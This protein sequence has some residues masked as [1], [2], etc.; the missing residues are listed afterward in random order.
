MNTESQSHGANEAGLHFGPI[1]RLPVILQQEAAE[2]GLACLAMVS[3]Y[4]RHAVDLPTLRHRFSLTPQG[5]TLSQLM[6]CAEQM[7]LMG[8]PVRLDLDELHDLQVPAILHWGLNH[9]VVLRKVGR[10]HIVIHDPAVGT[11]RISWKDAD[12][13]FTGVALELSP[14]TA[15]RRKSAPPPVAIRQL[16]GQIVGLKRSLV[17][18]FGFA[19]ALEACAL[20][21][22]L[23]TQ[24]VLDNVL[25]AGDLS[26]LN[27]LAISFTVLLLLQVAIGLARS[28]VLIWI[29]NQFTYGWTANVYRHL[30]R[31]PLNYFLARHLG[32][33]ASRFSAISAIQQTLT[34]QLVEAIVDGLMAAITLVMLLVYSP[35]L[36][37]IVVSGVA[38]Y[39]LSRI[40]FYSVFREANL[41]VLSVH[42]Q[43]QTRFLESVRGVQAIRLNNL[44]AIQS[45]R[46]MNAVA[47]SMNTDI[48]V[49][50]LSLGF[51]AFN[52]IATGLPR[53]LVLWA[54]AILALDG[55]LSAGMLLAF[56]AYADQFAQRGSALVDHVIQLRLL[57][58]QGERLAD[59]VLTPPE[60]NADGTYVGPTPRATLTLT[61]VGFRYGDAS[62]WVLRDCSLEVEEGE[63]VAIIGPSGCGKSTLLRLLS[64]LLEPQTG[65]VSMG[66]IPIG[67][68]GKR[69]FRE[70]ISC[71][72]QDD[73]LIA[74]TLADN[75]SLFDP[76]ASQEDIERA[77][78]LA[79]LHDDICDMPMGYSTLVGDMGSTLSGGQRQRVWLARAI[80]RNPRILILDEATSHLDLITEQAITAA[81]KERPITRIVVA[82]RPE[83]ISRAD[84]VLALMDG[85]LVEFGRGG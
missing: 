31:L 16:A 27:L 43:E 69:R 24:L 45:S 13:S 28:W 48:G 80:Y 34:A 19:L 62:P 51:G 29:G 9:F 71:V 76:K 77:A 70:S 10:R 66:D 59:I 74:G 25:S 44:E 20:L 61:G 73:Q 21:M 12:R 78:R 38:I 3:G 4:Y 82:H 35:K 15:F 30:I 64:G 23:F 41:N 39:C 37:L 14:T 36:A 85:Q 83:T 47:D 2:C 75:I 84:R 67:Q 17:K 18:I 68:L 46:Y 57:R 26:L 7:Q 81:L 42:A 11:R 40:M 50:R 58:L 8:R 79:Q 56:V 52:S 49:K 22:P 6:R 63:F 32:D 53:I 1:R 72:M 54:G 60:K 55:Q 33:I 5:L 65:T